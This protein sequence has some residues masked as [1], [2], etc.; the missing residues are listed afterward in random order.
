MLILV[1]TDWKLKHLF[2][3]NQWRNYSSYKRVDLQTL[4]IK[5]FLHVCRPALQHVSLYG[6]D[7]SIR[8]SIEHFNNTY[9]FQR[10]TAKGSDCTGYRKVNTFGGI[11]LEVWGNILSFILR[12]IRFFLNLSRC[13]NEA[14]RAEL[15]PT[16]IC[17][18][19]S[20]TEKELIEIW[21]SVYSNQTRERQFLRLIFEYVV[22]N[23]GVKR[24][25]SWFWKFLCEWVAISKKYLEFQE[26]VSKF[27][28][29]ADVMI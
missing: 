3:T 14:L 27:L 25:K 7:T 18:H 13:G 22:M 11:M 1:Y 6:S 28:S 16:Q 9:R 26:Q 17:Q 5:T 15:Y 8:F 24:F 29:D 21:K 12:S 23:Y 4:N 2:L 10:I 20:L 19:L